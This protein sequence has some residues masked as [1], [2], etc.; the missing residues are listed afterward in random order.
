LPFFSLDQVQHENNLS[1]KA[2]SAKA[3][4][5]ALATSKAD[6]IESIVATSRDSSTA[7]AKGMA[8]AHSAAL[9]EQQELHAE[10][11]KR[12]AAEFEAKV[13]RRL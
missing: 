3:A 13:E 12:M 5:D 4:Y 11:A 2:A 1:E 7:S 6:E 10:E 8:E 9:R